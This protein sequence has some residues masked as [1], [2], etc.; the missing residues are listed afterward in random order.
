MKRIS[1]TR[2]L[3]LTGIIIPAQIAAFAPVNFFPPYDTNYRFHYPDV[4]DDVS[5]RAGINFE[6]GSTSQ[7][8]NWR[9]KT[10]N[11]LRLYDESQN[12]I[13]MLLNPT[14]CIQDR[15]GNLLACI[16]GACAGHPTDDC[17]RGHVQLTG[18]FDGWEVTPHFRY[19]LPFD[20]LGGD[21][22]ISAH[23]PIRHAKV[24]GIKRCDLTGDCRMVDLEVKRLLTDVICQKTREFGCLDLSSWSQTGL[25][26]LVFLLDWMNAY[27]QTKE[28]LKEVTVHAK[29]GLSIP[30]GKEK[31]EDKAFSMPLG[32]GD[33]AWGIPFGI[34][35]DLY[36]KQR[37][38][39][40]GEAEFFILF[41]KTRLRR[42]KTHEFQTEFLLLNKG[43]A[44]KDHG[45]HWKFNIY[46][47]AYQ[48]WKGLSAKVTYQYFKHDDDRL[49]PSSDVFSS[50]IVNTA[51]SLKE[52]NM[53]H[54]IFQMSYDFFEER[55]HCWIKPQVNLFYKVPLTGRGTIEPH[56]FGGQ[57]GFNF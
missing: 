21:I 45:L 20:V 28:N 36:F 44:T 51:H 42:L 37:I 24:S 38:M 46:L 18:K 39:I 48:F 19:L 32:V 55:A 30:T 26:D 41:D 34:G 31:D 25:G 27:Y 23:L 33:G 3:L 54:F 4:D 9:G 15:V 56:T 43:K 49:T 17:Q 47:Q 12:T 1:L 35:L 22:G 13:A 5:Y 52:D 50:L 14:S 11:V 7:G 2:L 53:H 10:S 40:G 8:R 16:T 29:V 6:F 57:I